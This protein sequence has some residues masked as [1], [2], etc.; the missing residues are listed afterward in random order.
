MYVHTYI[1]YVCTV[2]GRM[3]KIKEVDMQA[4]HTHTHT[5]RTHAHE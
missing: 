3:E 1:M 5:V 2:V 4:S